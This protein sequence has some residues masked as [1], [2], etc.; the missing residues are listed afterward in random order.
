MISKSH[1]VELIFFG[2]N[3]NYLEGFKHSNYIHSI[4]D[5]VGRCEW[6][7]NTF[8][9][10]SSKVKFVVFE[11]CRAHQFPWMMP[12]IW[13]EGALKFVIC[14]H[15]YKYERIRCLLQRENISIFECKTYPQL[16]SS[17]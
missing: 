14:S 12:A 9:K 6:E 10:V 7:A 8:T 13:K 15:L 1:F 5:D 2:K 17:S 11:L 16:S 4:F 3:R